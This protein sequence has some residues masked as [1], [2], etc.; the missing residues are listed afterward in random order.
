MPTAS[1]PL[2][3]LPLPQVPLIDPKTGQPTQALFEWL[4]RLQATVTK[5]RSEIP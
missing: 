5:V 3:P 2:K 1:Q 4:E